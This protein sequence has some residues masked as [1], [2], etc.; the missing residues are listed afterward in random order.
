MDKQFFF[1]RNLLSLDRD[2]DDL[3]ERLSS[4]VTTKGRYRMLEAR[5]GLVVPSVVDGGGRAHPLHSL[6]DPVREAERLVSSAT[7]AGFLLFLGLGGG[8][9]IEAALASKGERGERVECAL[10]ID[11]DANGI[12]EILSHRDLVGVFH[13]PR[14]TLLV[15]PS[16]VEVEQRIL[17]AYKPLL[18]G[19]LRSIPLRTRCDAEKDRFVP[20]INAV[21]TAIEKIALD[22]SVQAQFGRRW[23][24]NTIRNIVRAETQSG[25]VPPI[26]HAAVCAAGPS[27][28][29][30]I[31]RLKQEQ[32]ERKPHGG[33]FVIATDTAFLTLAD[34]GITPDAVIAIDCQHIGYRHFLG[35]P[36]LDCTTRFF[37]DIAAPPHLAAHS[38]SPYFFADAHPL[39]AFA[40]KYYKSLP[41][42][43]VS[44]GNVT[45]AAVSLAAALRAWTITLYG[46]DFSYP[47]GR[48]YTRGA[49]I[50]PYF[51]RLQNRFQPTE[52]LFS[53][54]VFRSNTLTRKERGTSWFY[55]T[56]SLS[57]YKKTLAGY[58]A[59]LDS[60]VSAVEEYGAKEGEASPLLPDG[61]NP[62]SRYG[63][64]P[65]S[66]T[67]LSGALPR[68]APL[69]GLASPRPPGQSR[70][71]K[72]F[73]TGANRMN[74]GAFLRFYRDAI[75]SLPALTGSVE[76]YLA[77]LTPFQT[78]AFCTLIPLGASVKSSAAQS[79]TQKAV[80]FAEVLE[81]TKRYAAALI[82]KV[83]AAP[84]TYIKTEHE[85]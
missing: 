12:A 66:G 31:A 50:Y 83:S 72:I 46:A 73:S 79:A 39:S 62:L 7:G 64:V 77:S 36:P 26:T 43:D 29:G 16:P 70:P 25:A 41:P 67:P 38:P 42:I 45:Y 18:H 63:F 78:E 40:A 10:I 58:A 11:F 3:C 56:P 6:I 85:I 60:E 53:S 8:Y 80:E 49:Y 81:E 22:Y 1:E 24:S 59:G 75:R 27:L 19:N 55:E 37:L 34:N 52:T 51:D 17:A 13:D 69:G 82:D 57:M 33:L 65:S 68:N 48:T 30:Q 20:V 84:K 15:D 47:E 9:Q 32:A 71:L 54:F 28:D 74:A 23:F 35:G 76:G 21:N 14:V 2:G 4:A 5:G 44:G 61:T